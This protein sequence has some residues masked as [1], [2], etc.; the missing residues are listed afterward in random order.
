MSGELHVIGTK[1]LLSALTNL[2]P[3]GCRPSYL[4]IGVLTLLWSQAPRPATIDE[5][6]DWIYG[7]KED[8][9]P[10][11]AGDCIR[12]AINGLRKKGYP[13]RNSYRWGYY[14]PVAA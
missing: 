3:R 1:A 11:Y 8:G 5:L 12:V 13:I 6:I 10:D 2:Q 9:G 7:D 4:R 14:I